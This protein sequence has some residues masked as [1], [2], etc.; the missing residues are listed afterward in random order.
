MSLSAPTVIIKGASATRV[1]TAAETLDLNTTAIDIVGAPGARL[2]LLPRA[3][4]LSKRSGVVGAAGGNITF[5]IGTNSITANLSRANMFPAA[6]RTY[7]VG[8]TMTTCS[9]IRTWG[10]TS[11]WRRPT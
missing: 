5:R 1:L 4:I 10:S 6:A 9:S 11:T 7:R 2:A 3:F 8:W